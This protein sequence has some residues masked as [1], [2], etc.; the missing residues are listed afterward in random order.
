MRLLRTQAHP[1]TNHVLPF[2]AITCLIDQLAGEHHLGE[3]A[4]N[5][6]DQTNDTRKSPL[7]PTRNSRLV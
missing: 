2:I 1:S 7:I 3:D 5:N 6:N 4:V